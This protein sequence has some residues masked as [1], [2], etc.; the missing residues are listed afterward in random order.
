MMLDR[1]GKTKTKTSVEESCKTVSDN[2]N[3]RTKKEKTSTGRKDTS[4]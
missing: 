2:E 4:K 3:K 1:E